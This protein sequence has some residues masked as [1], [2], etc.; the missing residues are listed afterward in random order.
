MQNVV[1]IGSGISGLSISRMLS[2]EFNVEIVE[3]DPKYG[4]LIKCDRID[5]NLFHRVGGHVFNSRNQL[6]LDWFWSHFDKENE[7]IKTS[8]NAKI[9]LNSDFIGYPIENY[10]YQLPKEQLIPIL[11]EL[12]EKLSNDKHQV[13]DYS[14]F[15][16]FLIGNFGEELYNLYFGPYN[17][18][19]WNSDLDKVPLE[20]LDQKLP[21]PNLREVLL[22]NIVK[23]EE[24]KMVHST[25][26]YPRKD[27]SQFI[28]NRLS[29]GLSIQCSYEVHSINFIEKKGLSINNDNKI[30]NY[31]IYCGDV[32]Q[33][34]NIVQIQDETLKLAL[35]N[36]SQLISNGTSNVLC[37]TDVNDISWLY[38]PEANLMAHRIIY[39]GNFSDTNNEGTFRKTCVV[40][41]SG[42][43]NQRDMIEELKKLPGNLKPL[44]FN[45]EPN[46][47]VVQS[48][49]DREYIRDLKLLLEPYG[50]YLLGRF[51]E[52]EYYN[53]DKCIEA[54]INLKQKL[55]N[56]IGSKN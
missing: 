28:V 49:K 22:S 43:Q 1:V 18:K 29:E 4:G 10:L 12:I 8:R 17:T 37:E 6:V 55:L 42:K 35:K 39:T 44:A 38:L 7:F 25:F 9:L 14:S 32:R 51:A 52:W 48:S 19:I 53:M 41:F 56:N 2:E 47:Y 15:K 36:V 54:A 40:E 31:I 27:G 13:S 33:L 20:W 3:R 11:N 46:S 21:M 5:G 24:S 45:Y 26:F 16:S 34:I 30:S 23:N 50:I